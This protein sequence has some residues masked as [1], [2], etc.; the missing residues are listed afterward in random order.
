MVLGLEFCFDIYLACP[1]APS[2]SM[3][4]KVNLSVEGKS[5]QADTLSL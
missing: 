4:F 1:P 5:N 2:I 3:F